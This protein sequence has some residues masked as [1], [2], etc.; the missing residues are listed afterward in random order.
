[1]PRVTLP[2]ITKD[3]VGTTTTDEAESLE[4]LGQ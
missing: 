3:P 2:I 4:L 1:M